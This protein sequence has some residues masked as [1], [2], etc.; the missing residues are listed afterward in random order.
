MCTVLLPPGV[1]PIAVNK[2]ININLIFCTFS[3]LRAKMYLFTYMKQKAPDNR[4]VLRSVYSCR[5]SVRNLL[6]VT[7]PAPRI[8]KWLLEFIQYLRTFPL[9]HYIFHIFSLLR[10]HLIHPTIASLNLQE[11]LHI[12]EKWLKKWKIKVN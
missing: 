7:L 12:I 2:Y 10:R 6:Y 9:G 5:F 3:S 8:W 4:E 11:H 1:N